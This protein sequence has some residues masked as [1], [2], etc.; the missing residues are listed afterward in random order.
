[1]AGHHAAETFPVVE[2]RGC[3][4]Q[5]TA[6][7]WTYSLQTVSQRATGIQ[8]E[9][10]S[11]AGLATPERYSLYGCSSQAYYTLSIRMPPMVLS[12]DLDRL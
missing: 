5:K 11:F 2:L 6:V 8:Q 12:S 3:H 9:P 4:R 1:M 10:H 7:I